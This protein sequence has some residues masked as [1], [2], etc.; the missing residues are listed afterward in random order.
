MKNPVDD[1]VFDGL[2]QLHVNGDFAAKIQLQALT[3]LIGSLLM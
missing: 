2:G 1:I 3:A